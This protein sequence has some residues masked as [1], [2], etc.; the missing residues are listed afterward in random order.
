MAMPTNPDSGDGTPNIRLK[1]S[2]RP[3]DAA[4]GAAVAL[5]HYSPEGIIY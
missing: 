1:D 2:P 5:C 3:D 4:D